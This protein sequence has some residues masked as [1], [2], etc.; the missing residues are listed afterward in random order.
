MLDVR[1]IV[2]EV[3]SHSPRRVGPQCDRAVLRSCRMREMK[4]TLRDVKLGGCLKKV[5]E[6]A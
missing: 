2:T 4:L 1:E 6:A 5:A 3:T